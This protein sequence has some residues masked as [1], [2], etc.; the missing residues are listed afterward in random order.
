[1]PRRKCSPENT[2][3]REKEVEF[4]IADL[5]EVLRIKLDGGGSGEVEYAFDEATVFA[6]D[7]E[8]ETVPREVVEDAGVV[9]GYVH[10]ANEAG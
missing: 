3:Y 2:P 7:F 10:A 4:F 5:E 1:M 9:A 6:E 8:C